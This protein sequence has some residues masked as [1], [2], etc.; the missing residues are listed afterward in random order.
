MQEF[1]GAIAWFLQ[2]LA[3]RDVNWRLIGFR[4][5]HT[6]M[7]RRQPVASDGSTGTGGGMHALP[8]AGGVR[9]A[10]WRGGNGCRRTFA[11]AFRL[12]RHRSR[13]RREAARGDEV[14]SA[15]GRVLDL[16]VVKG[17]MHAEGEVARQRPRRRR[18]RDEL[19]A[20]GV[21]DDG[22]RDH[23]RRI[24]DVLVVQAGLEVGE[25]G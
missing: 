16:A 11:L 12:F 9:R 8:P 19:C 13:Q 5:R 21:V 18:P 25:R 1:P 22:E 24:G 10:W 20:E 2:H 17:G 23:H 4:H 7:R 15:R 6:C 3:W 14:Y